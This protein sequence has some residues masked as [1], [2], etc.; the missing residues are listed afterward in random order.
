MPDHLLL[1]A[2][3]SRNPGAPGYHPLICHLIDAAAVADVLY[4][5]VL[6]PAVRRSVSA[7]L[8]VDEQDTS[9]LVPVLA[10]LHDIGKAT[11]VFQCRDPVG[12]QRL[13]EAGV[14]FGRSRSD[15]GHGRTGAAILKSL[16]QT[17]FLWDRETSIQL[18]L[19]IG[20]HHG[21][22][23]GDGEFRDAGSSRYI[24][25]PGWTGLRD[26]LINSLLTVLDTTPAI[27]ER[28]PSHAAT[29]ILAGLISV[30]DWIASDDS[31]FAYAR[32]DDPDD[33][34][35]LD[36]V[37]YR[38]TA[39]DS[40]ERALA[41]L[42]WLDWIPDNADLDFADL[43]PDLAR[44][45][46]P[47]QQRVTALPGITDNPGVAILELPMGE[48][49]TEAAFSLADRWGH[50]LGQRGVYIA[51]PTMA[52][53]NQMYGRAQEF[54]QHRFP[55][56]A[57]TVQLLHSHAALGPDD[58]AAA[59]HAPPV[60]PSQSHTDDP[61]QTDDE[62]NA[63]TGEWFT[64][65]K[66]GLLAPFGV[67]TVDQTLLAAL[68]TKHV[69]VRLFGL[70]GK[71]VI[72]D[73]VH[74]YDAYMSRLFERVLEWLGALGSSVIVLSATLP[75]SR[76]RAMISAYARG[77]TGSA[78]AAI[79]ATDYPR[80]SWL[81]PNRG[82]AESI[83]VSE[84]ARRTLGLEWVDG[85]P[86]ALSGF[87]QSRL[88]DGGCAAIICNTVGRA[89]DVYRKLK[90]LFSGVADDGYPELDLF[91]ARFPFRTRLERE[92]RA[93]ARFGKPADPPDS[94]RPA[95][96]ILVATQVIEQ[97][98]DLDFDLMITDLA[99]VDLILQR[100]G[101][102]HRHDRT[103]SRPAPLTGPPVIYVTAP[104]LRDGLPAFTP[105]DKYIY[106]EHVLLRTWWT[107]EKTSRIRIP[108]DLGNL[109]EAVYDDRPAPVSLPVDLRELWQTSLAAYQTALEE[110][111][112]QAEYRWIQSPGYSE[113]I[114]NIVRNPLAEDAPD[115]HTTHQ[116]LTRLG[117]PAV[118]IVC[119]Y[120]ADDRPTLDQDGRVPVLT[121]ET[122]TFPEARDLLRNAVSIT[123]RRI[124]D[125]LL[126]V[127]PPANW[128]RSSLLR[129]HRCVVFDAD[130]RTDVGGHVLKNDPDL[131]LL[132]ETEE[133]RND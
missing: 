75:D 51:M 117:G 29:M 90:P 27:I 100:S 2:K 120:G 97:S 76:R 108:D 26:Q 105:A 133:A 36:L 3:T 125:H 33:P 107:L 68:Q 11:P 54:L 88:A 55:E 79:E 6:T 78:P 20:G 124:V 84:N 67:G 37:R 86:S 122:P 82:L 34:P 12:L 57:I 10:G 56:Q 45:P 110:E 72:F 47:V 17:R 30:S 52:T 104:E 61:E 60:S 32:L 44:S 111:E 65:R 71:T 5:R 25:G 24:G 116:A 31:F 73:E 80:I 4:R 87:L 126:K 15:P 89:Q 113:M 9:Q 42:G 91:H 102:L 109:I 48:G 38:A 63:R 16:F 21:T 112:R 50:K 35:Q 7:G 132:V 106:S 85:D 18:A 53:A 115:V 96:A 23:P 19:A 28:K 77:R 39:S 70:A 92:Q 81:G 131:G 99:P 130:G 22:F 59:E 129:N 94:Q 128:Q 118:S 101:R 98:L 58:D 43:F 62:A 13:T 93:L 121:D 74:A 64:R 41:A 46:R 69:F 14:P 8:G 95:R 114:N 1:W 119:L 127:E 103:D 49:K 66:R 123:D 40:A 83:P